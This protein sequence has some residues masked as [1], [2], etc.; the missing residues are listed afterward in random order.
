MSLY[1]GYAKHIDDISDKTLYDE[2]NSK[3]NNDDKLEPITSDTYHAPKFTDLQGKNGD[4]SEF[5]KYFKKPE[6]F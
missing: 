3:L 4:F 2:V 6:P 5:Y 1:L